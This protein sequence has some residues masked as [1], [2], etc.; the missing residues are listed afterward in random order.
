MSKRAK[1][2]I[3]TILLAVGFVGINLIENEFKTA[4]ILGLSLATLLLFTWSLKE[5]IGFNAT[6]L[7]LVLP[8]LYTLGVGIFWFLLPASLIARVPV[9]LLYSIGIYSLALT[10]NIFTV[11]AVR[12]IA[13]SRAAKGVGFVLTLFTAFLL[14]DAVLSLKAQIFI[15]ALLIYLVS[16]PLFLQ[17]LWMSKITKNI[18]KELFIFSSILSYLVTTSAIFLY[19][20][21]VTLVVG[22]IFLTVEVYVYLGLGQARVEGRLFRQTL[23]EYALVGILVFLTMIIVTNWRG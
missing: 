9:I 2:I 4:G 16:F 8:T 5:G 12:T 1:I 22:S 3:T 10:N 6:A 17:G 14:Y 7:V 11:S 23:R 13:L 21:P 18:D 20:W 15:N 19:F